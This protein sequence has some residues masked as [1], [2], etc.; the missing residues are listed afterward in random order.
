[1]NTERWQHL[2][3]NAF[4]VACRCDHCGKDFMFYRAVA[5]CID[6]FLMGHRGDYAGLCRECGLTGGTTHEMKGDN[7]K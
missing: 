3:G 7:N 1:M 4:T 5:L 6:C 2:K